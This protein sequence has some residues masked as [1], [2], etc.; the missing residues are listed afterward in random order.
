LISPTP[1]HLPPDNLMYAFYRIRAIHSLIIRLI[2]KRGKNLYCLKCQKN[3]GAVSTTLKVG[4]D[5]TY[6]QTILYAVYKIRAIHSLLI[7]LIT[8]VGKNLWFLKSQKKRGAVLTIFKVGYDLLPTLRQFDV[9]FLQ[10]PCDPL[11]ANQADIQKRQEHLLLEKPKRPRRC[12]HNTEGRNR[13]HLPSD[14]LMYA[15]YRNRAIHSV[16]IKLIPR[17]GKNLYLKSQ[18]N[19]GAVLAIFKAGY[20]L[21][22]T[23]R[24]FDVCFLQNSCDSLVA[25]QADIQKRHEPL[26]LEKPKEP[27]RCF[28]NTEGRIR[29]HLPPDNLCDSLVHKYADDL[30]GNRKDCSN[31]RCIPGWGCVRQNESYGKCSAAC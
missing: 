30:T 5:P 25:N 10:H 4:F 16:L 11:V 6:P 29:S 18:K 17:I 24:Q 23:L 2:S 26:L 7:K 31:I 12:F 1:S 13:S 22:P 14:N 21:L 19:R 27:R 20:D 8:R 9:G 15:V 3:R 28:H